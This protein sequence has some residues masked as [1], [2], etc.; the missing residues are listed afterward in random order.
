MSTS[1]LHTLACVSL[2]PDDLAAAAIIGGI[3]SQMLR[4]G[5]E[6]RRETTSGAYYP[7][8]QAV[9]SRTP[10]ADW[11]TVQIARALDACSFTGLRVSAATDPGVKFFGNKK[12][13]GGIR[14]SGSNHIQFLQRDGLMFPERIT[15]EYQQDAEIFYKHLVTYDGTNDVWSLSE[16]VALP[17]QTADD[18]RYTIGSIQLGTVTGDKLVLAQVKSLEINFGISAQAEGS[19]SDLEPTFASIDEIMPSISITLTDATLFDSSGIPLNGKVVDSSHT[20][21]HLR[22]RSNNSTFVADGTT[23]HISF[24]PLSG[25]AYHDSIF[26][27]RHNGNGT[28]TIVIPLL[29]DSSLTAPLAIDTTAAIALPS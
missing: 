14:A 1:L 18:Q 29:S 22:Q 15:C 2:F 4:S 25:C 8:F 17:T 10:S 19:D 12:S 11:S 24:V 27:V 13:E 21:I 28:V 23:T 3:R 5:T 6:V 20:I 16:S 7:Q 9:Y 26:D